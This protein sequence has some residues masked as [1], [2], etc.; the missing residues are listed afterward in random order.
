MFE[1][2]DDMNKQKLDAIME[3]LHIQPVGSGYVDCICP[4][5]N[6]NAFIDALNQLGIEVACFTWWEYVPP[7]KEN[8]YGMGGPSN[9]YGP[10]WYSEVSKLGDCIHI[11]GNEKVREYLLNEWPNSKEYKESFVPGFWLLVPDAW[12]NSFMDSKK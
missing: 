12:D 1:G 4:K 3:Q 2:C 5:E 10:G 9:H 7:F 6:I 11:E 8:Q